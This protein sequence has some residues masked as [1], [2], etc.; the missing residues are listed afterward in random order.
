[1]KHSKLLGVKVFDY[2]NSKIATLYVGK[3]L[4]NDLKTKYYGTTICQ[5]TLYD[6][7][8]IDKAIELV[9]KDVIVYFEPDYKG[10]AKIVDIVELKK[11]V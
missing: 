9:G 6:G 11:E 7:A 8:L 3:S 5:Y 4:D 10:Y 2:N 1:M